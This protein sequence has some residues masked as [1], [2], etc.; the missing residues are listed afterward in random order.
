MNWI[1]NA[2]LANPAACIMSGSK[3]FFVEG[4]VFELTHIKDSCHDG[5]NESS[6]QLMTVKALSVNEEG[7]TE[8]G[9]L[10]IERGDV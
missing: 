10:S 5:K 1:C 9:I 7:V 4:W 8:P 3:I 2:T 6:T